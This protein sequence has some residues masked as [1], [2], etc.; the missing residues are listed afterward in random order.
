YFWEIQ[1]PMKWPVYYNSSKKVLEEIGFLRDI[2]GCEGASYINFVDLQREI[3]ALYKENT[4]IEIKYPYW[5][6]EHVLWKQFLNSSTRT[7]A[8]I[9][10][11]KPGTGE[12]K[13][14]KGIVVSQVAN[15]WLPPII[16]DLGD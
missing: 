8:A 5:F 3:Q 13:P 7:G 6:V 12:Q 4:K 9:D 15:E 1:N 14:S 11:Q 2:Q 16:D 10:K